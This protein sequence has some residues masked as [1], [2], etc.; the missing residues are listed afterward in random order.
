MDQPWAGHLISGVGRSNHTKSMKSLCLLPFAARTSFPVTNLQGKESQTLRQYRQTRPHAGGATSLD[1][2]P[3]IREAGL[4]P[5][6]MLL[7]AEHAVGLPAHSV[8]PVGIVACHDGGPRTTDASTMGLAPSLV[9]SMF[10]CTMSTQVYYIMTI[11]LSV[12]VTD[13]SDVDSQTV[14]PLV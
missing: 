8:A 4:C 6:T 9:S 2:Y 1:R 7:V 5:S 10:R 13:C 3:I 14:S 12:E 11:C